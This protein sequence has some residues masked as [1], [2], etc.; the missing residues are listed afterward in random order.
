MRP[1]PQETCYKLTFTSVPISHKFA[2]FLV[3]KQ[4]ARTHLPDCCFT[5]LFS[6][7]NNNKYLKIDI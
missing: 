4:Y 6:A 2:S 5:F 7:K 1:N 3:E